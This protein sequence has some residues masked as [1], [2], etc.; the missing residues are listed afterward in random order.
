M[1]TQNKIYFVKELCRLHSEYIAFSFRSNICRT[2]EICEQMEHIVGWT[3]GFCKYDGQELMTREPT[4]IP[5]LI[6]ITS[7]PSAHP[8]SS[9][10]LDCIHMSDMESCNL[11][12]FCK[13]TFCSRQAKVS[14]KIIF[15]KKN[16]KFLVSG[17]N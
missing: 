12:S 13:T 15:C 10:Y 11:L 9:N 1:Y 6:P 14:D 7:S 2:Y 8:H 3:S 4:K 17:W 16:C 5:T